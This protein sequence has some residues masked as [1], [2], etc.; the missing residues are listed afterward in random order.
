MFKGLVK[1]LCS[2]F[3]CFYSSSVFA[4]EKTTITIYFI[5]NPPLTFIDDKGAFQGKAINKLRSVLDHSGVPYKFELATWPRPLRDLET[6]KETLFLLLARTPTRENA[7][8]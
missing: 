5:Q 8:S 4:D 1:Y 7:F 2:L 3:I 6:K